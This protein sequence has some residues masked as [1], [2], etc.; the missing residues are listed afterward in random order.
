M[1]SNDHGA[2]WGWLAGAIV[3]I[4]ILVW[5]FTQPVQ[6]KPVSTDGC[7]GG[8]S[9]FY[10]LTTGKPPAFEY[11]CHA[12]DR[13]Y[14]RGGTADARAKADDKLGA[15]VAKHSKIAGIMWF[16][17]RAAGQPFHMYDWK[18]Y[19]R[20]YVTRWQYERDRPL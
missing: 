1:M 8:V 5:A 11:C 6:A 10:R 3:L 15:C 17:V 19:R 2:W 9:K 16:A 20:D 12:H 14:A 13:A 7:S 18:Q 4:L